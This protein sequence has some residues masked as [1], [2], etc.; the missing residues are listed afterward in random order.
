MIGDKVSDID[1][2]YNP[3]IKNSILISSEYSKSTDILKT[4]HIKKYN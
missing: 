2:A 1:L 4:E 3:G